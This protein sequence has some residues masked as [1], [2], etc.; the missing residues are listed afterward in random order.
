MVG[1]SSPNS[2]RYKKIELPKTSNVERYE[3][4]L[5][6][7]ISQEVI[8]Y[9]LYDTTIFVANSK[10][11]VD[12]GYLDSGKLIRTYFLSGQLKDSVFF[13]GAYPEGISKSYYENGNLKYYSFYMDGTVVYLK[14]FNRNGE[15]LENFYT[16]I[17]VGDI[18]KGGEY[19]LND[20][21]NLSFQL[22]HTALKYPVIIYVLVADDQDTIDFLKSNELNVNFNVSGISVDEKLDLWMLELDSLGHLYGDAKFEYPLT[23]HRGKN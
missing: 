6:S 2:T 14:E 10:V 5:N 18:A 15:I 13:K 21:L 17:S 23:I 7:E 19:D 1:C 16:A 9:G 3:R 22:I 20:T 8:N 12:S 4:Y 11:I